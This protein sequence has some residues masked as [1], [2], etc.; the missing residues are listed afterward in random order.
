MDG[1][2]VYIVIWNLIPRKQF[3]PSS[4]QFASIP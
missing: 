3:F 4:F 1:M 2:G